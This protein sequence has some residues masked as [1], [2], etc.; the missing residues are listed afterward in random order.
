M[1]LKELDEE[2]GIETDALPVVGKALIGD[3]LY[4]ERRSRF[5]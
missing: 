5:R 2:V 4:H 1:I 3:R